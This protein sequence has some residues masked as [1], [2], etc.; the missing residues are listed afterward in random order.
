M[1]S[2]EEVDALRESRQAR[3]GR[4]KDILLESQHVFQDETT[5]DLEG[6]VA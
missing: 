2:Q 4:W 3:K 5:M 6:Q 1:F